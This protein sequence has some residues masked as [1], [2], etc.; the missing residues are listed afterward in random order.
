MT[1]Q[2]LQ[3]M[4]II[5]PHMFSRRA[6]ALLVFAGA[7]G[8]C[9]AIERQDAAD[10]EKLLA[11]GGFHML[12]ADSAERQA[13]LANMPPRRIVA[14]RQ[15][16][17]TVYTYADTQNCRCLYIGGPRAYAKYREFALSDATVRDMGEAAMNSASTDFPVWPSWDARW[18]P[19]DAWD[20]PDPAP[21]DF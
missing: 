18:A 3:P 15:G 2:A 12:P 13:D 6:A 21:F 11:A 1:V 20:D 9:S 5:A 17:Q 8:G 16:A 10:T 4:K 19:T 7:L 14:R